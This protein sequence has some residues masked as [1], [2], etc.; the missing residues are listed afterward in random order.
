MACM[1]CGMALRDDGPTPVLPVSTVLSLLDAVATESDAEAPS[2]SAIV[3]ADLPA[4]VSAELEERVRNLRS[5]LSR[6]RRRG[7]ELS[8]LFSSAHELAE[9]RD[10][11]VL[12]HRLVERAHDLLGTDVTYLSEFYEGSD[13]LRVRS[14]LG[15]VAPSFREL[16]VPSGMGLA[17]KVVRTGCPQWTSNYQRHHDIPHEASIDAA[18]AAEGLVSLLGVPLVAGERV[19][20]VLF[21]ANRSEQIGRASCRE[22]V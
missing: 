8:A 11:D 16:R 22:R 10:T 12:L 2:L 7:Q 14:T 18:V 4:E 5:L 21:A 1:L 9:L 17:T 6:L 19:L 13:E 20:G 15:T 3:G